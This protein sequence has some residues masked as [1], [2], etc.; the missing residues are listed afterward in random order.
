MT[1]AEANGWGREFPLLGPLMD[2]E[3]FTRQFLKQ[4]YREVTINQYPN[5]CGGPWPWLCRP[6]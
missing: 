5:S 2:E 6:W 3:S 4:T 1:I